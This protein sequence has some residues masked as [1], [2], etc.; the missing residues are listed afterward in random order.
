MMISPNAERAM[1][2][3]AGAMESFLRT[4]HCTGSSIRLKESKHSFIGETTPSGF[5]RSGAM[6]FQASL[7]AIPILLGIDASNAKSR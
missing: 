6:R 3:F 7:L 4:F 2:R 5:Y 1:E